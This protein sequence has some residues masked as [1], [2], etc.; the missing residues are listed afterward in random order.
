MVTSST[1][2]S[3][4][5][6]LVNLPEYQWDQVPLINDIANITDLKRAIYKQLPF[7]RSFKVPQIKLKATKKVDVINK[8]R[9]FASRDTLESVLETFKVEVSAGADVQQLFAANV[10]IYVVPPT[11]LKRNREE[12]FV[13][14]DSKKP[15]TESNTLLEAIDHARLSQRAVKDGVCN[16]TLLTNKEKI[17]VL[18]Y[19]GIRSTAVSPYN[20]LF[21]TA[22]TLRD[23]SFQD[24]DLISS[25][26]KTI[27]PVIG[28]RQLYV[29]QEYKDLYNE[30]DKKFNGSVKE[31]VKKHMV[32]TGTEGI[33]KSV[34]LVY[35]T[36][37]ILA[38]S[39][40][41][42]PPI[43]I[44]QEKER[45]KCYAFGGLST[46]RSCDGT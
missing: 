19:I 43:I 3:K 41:D 10:W 26:S 25:P 21:Q 2:P 28:M 15:K 14:N 7:V 44:F 31:G 4:V 30:I 35:F 38:T 11:A 33:G 6:F 27:L 9:E 13:E 39:S 45:S 12:D 36:I 18:D 5:W 29:R 17:S 46:V 23:L 34:F 32:V 8:A 37:R 1:A 20:I 42:N 16:L 40:E 24:I 22:T